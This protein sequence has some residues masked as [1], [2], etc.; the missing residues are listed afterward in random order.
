MYVEF[1]PEY[2]KYLKSPRWK[3]FCQRAYGFYGKKCMACGSR[4][5]LHVHHCTYD[6]LGRELLGDV[7][8]VC[9]KCHRLIHQIHR[10]NRNISLL[11]VTTRYIASKKA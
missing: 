8:V 6:R 11:L 4:A 1:T 3:A 5:K 9:D 10:T 2:E 7:R